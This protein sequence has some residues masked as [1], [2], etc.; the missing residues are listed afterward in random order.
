M[1]YIKSDWC[2]EPVLGPDGCV[3]Q[4][5]NNQ[6]IKVYDYPEWTNCVLKN[7]ND[8]HDGTINLHEFIDNLTYN[9][10]YKK[11]SGYN[12]K[13]EYHCFGSCQYHS[14]YKMYLFLH[15]LDYCDIDTSEFIGA[16]SDDFL[17]KKG[18]Q[19][20][21][22]NMIKAHELELIV[23]HNHKSLGYYLGEIIYDI[24]NFR[25]PGELNEEFDYEQQ[26]KK[27]YYWAPCPIK[28]ITKEH[29]DI[30]DK[31]VLEF[32]NKL[33]DKL[34]IF[35]L[36][37]SELEKILKRFCRD[38][39]VKYKCDNAK[40]L[41]KF[42]D[43]VFDENQIMWDHDDLIDNDASS[44]TIFEVPVT[45]L[46]NQ[47]QLDFYRESH[48]KTIKKITDLVSINDFETAIKYFMDG[49]DMWTN[50]PAIFEMIYDK[51]INCVDAPTIKGKFIMNDW[52]ENYKIGA[53]IY[54]MVKNGIVKYVNNFYC[55]NT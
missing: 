3:Y 10:H 55:P 5:S 35:N 40:K 12:G 17:P 39:N 42:S 1:Q 54:V 19:Q 21:L 2:E 37:E 23:P 33:R 52:S 41:E 30:L 22:I 4:Y 44:M 51:E 38:P 8:Y 50:I 34:K 49:G 9:E 14:I 13:L 15:I 16:K 36:S 6:L 53:Q 48:K 29:L 31:K 26:S 24:D 46:N 11:A 7:Y 28:K 45:A 18:Y 43:Y 27:E 47:Q 32:S 25:F 20:N